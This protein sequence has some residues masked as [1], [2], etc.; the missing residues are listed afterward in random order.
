MSLHRKLCSYLCRVRELALFLCPIWN[1]WFLPWPQIRKNVCVLG[2][3]W[4]ARISRRRCH[5]NAYMLWQH[6]DL[7]QLNLLASRSFDGGMVSL[8]CASSGSDMLEKQPLKEETLA[9]KLGAFHL[10]P[11][12]RL[13]F[14]QVSAMGMLGTK[15]ST[16][17]AYLHVNFQNASPTFHHTI[18]MLLYLFCLGTNRG[19]GPEVDQRSVLALPWLSLCPTGWKPDC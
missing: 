10:C 13:V 16:W 18:V 15:G 17:S 3:L 6:I 19:E 5:S 1:I 9:A 4:A 2:L 12:F 14:L 8:I 11:L 7:L